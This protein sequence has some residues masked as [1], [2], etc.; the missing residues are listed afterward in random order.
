MVYRLGDIEFKQ[1]A[2]P[3][4]LLKETTINYVERERLL[5]KPLL[6]KV[7]GTL[8]TIEL[9]IYFH[10]SFSEVRNSVNQIRDAAA[11]GTSMVLIN[12]AGLKEGEYVI[13]RH[14]VTYEKTDNEGR[15]L[16]ANMSLQ[17]KEFVSADKETDEAIAA[18][19]K[20]FANI[21]A[22]PIQ[23]S[24]TI[25]YQNPQSLAMR[26]ISTTQAAA[27]SGSSNLRKAAAVPALV[28][29]YMAVAERSLKRAQQD[30]QEAKT[31]VDGVVG[32]ITNATQLK[33]N[34]DTVVSTIGTMLGN[35]NEANLP[36]LQNA[37]TV[38]DQN[39]STLRTTAV[40]LSN[41]TALRK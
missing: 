24:P 25:R 29:K 19:K 27:T 30:A 28:K 1:L 7:G 22:N 17:L 11:S 41:V 37:A 20:G 15:L 26:K 32:K 13:T 40:Q 38:L 2:T 31:A 14:S 39:I 8:D 23:T 35:F 6:Q 10:F 4:P 18:R 21:S 16:I 33:D 12:G 34:L 5:D 9:D 36:N 3:K